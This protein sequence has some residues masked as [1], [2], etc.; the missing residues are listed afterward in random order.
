M[1]SADQ[2]LG[3]LAMTA[4]RYDVRPGSSW[5]PTIDTTRD[6]IIAAR[7]PL[8]WPSWQRSEDYYA[9]G[10]LIWLDV[11]T[12]IRELTGETRSLDDFAHA[13]FGRDDGSWA[14]STY[15]FEEVVETL[16][17]IV[18]FDWQGFFGEQLT[19]TH[20]RA[21]L[22]GIG[23]GGYRLVYRDGPSDYQKSYEAVFGSIDLTHSLGLTTSPDGKISD[24]LW[25]GPAFE[26]GL[27]IGTTIHAVDG[28]EF[29]PEILGN[30]VAASRDGVR[31]DIV[32]AKAA[33]TVTIA[34]SEGL[35]YP[36]LQAKSDAPGRLDEILRAL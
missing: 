3:A 7:A 29:S 21:P 10:A 4:A 6:P 18:Q 9:E 36:H 15:E 28:R 8:P 12:R 35:R 2:A 25:D 16:N 11:D 24:V 23:R 34:C 27:T 32:Q 19:Q 5:R 20:D 14:T 33:R 17:A 13:F 26:A 30:A 22:A 1:W 31:L